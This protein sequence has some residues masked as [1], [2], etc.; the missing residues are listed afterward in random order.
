[1]KNEKLF[2]AKG[3]QIIVTKVLAGMTKE[4]RLKVIQMKCLFHVLK[5][6]RPMADFTAMW[7]LLLN[8]MF[9][10]LVVRHV[11]CDLSLG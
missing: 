3:S 4:W 9:R 10:P 5:Q 6:G 11:E 2:F 1:M 7:E 8:L